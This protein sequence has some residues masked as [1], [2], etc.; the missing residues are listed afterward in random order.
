MDLNFEF[1][2]DI[3]DCFKKL[4]INKND[5]I[6]ITGNL[7]ALGRIKIEKILLMSLFLKA[8]RNRIGKNANIFSPSA[9]MNLMN[10][11][12]PFDIDNTPSYEM[13]AFAEYFRKLPDSIRSN[14]P[15]WSISGQGSDA[16]RLKNVSK[17]SYGAGSPWTI[18]LELEVKQ[19]TMGIHP[20]KAVSL[21]HH[22]E[23]I[24][25]V[26]YRYTKEFMQPIKYGEKII[27]EK[28]YQSV[29]YKDCLIK[30]KISLNKHFFDELEL[31]GKL[32]K[33]KH[34]SGLTFWSFKMKDFY[35]VVLEFLK[36]DIY[37]YLEEPPLERP[38][39]N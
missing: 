20:S 5:N 12:V 25:G 26:P 33:T 22:I 19:I 7:G 23:T 34:L 35:K 4:D 6:Y 17:H 9:S 36:K 27:E 11:N 28:F 16:F 8:L 38:Y 21:I 37:T 13:G 24:F 39:S 18:F 1:E 3:T 29:M 2:N 30:K 32:L 10:T 14:H 15:F 31:Q